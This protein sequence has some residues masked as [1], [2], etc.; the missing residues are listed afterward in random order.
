MY[1]K[2]FIRI[3]FSVIV[4]KEKVSFW[5][6]SSVLLSRVI[7]MPNFLKGL[8]RKQDYVHTLYSAL[9]NILERSNVPLFS[10]Y[11]PEEK[12]VFTA[13]KLTGT[14]HPGLRLLQALL[15]R[16]NPIS[17]RTGCPSETRLGP[18]EQLVRKDVLIPSALHCSFPPE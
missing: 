10:S 17:F 9:K 5:L 4:Q 6:S 3:P 13:M 16:H 14:L 12:S 2:I 11:Y 8:V 1:A 7:N 18:P 15:K